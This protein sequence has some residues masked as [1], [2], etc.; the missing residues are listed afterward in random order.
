MK[1]LIVV[2]LIGYAAW[3]Y[4]SAS[5][6]VITSYSIHYTKLYEIDQHGLEAAV[7][8]ELLADQPAHKGQIKVDCARRASQ[9]GPG[10]PMQGAGEKLR[11]EVVRRDEIPAKV[12]SYNF[13]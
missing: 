9:Q 1:K 10:R 11:K 2:V 8:A 4:Y 13:V 12:G 3:H 6:P 7:G 5:V